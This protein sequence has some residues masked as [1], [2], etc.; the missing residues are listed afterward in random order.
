MPFR[1]GTLALVFGKPVQPVTATVSEALEPSGALP[2]STKVA[3][4]HP[5]GRVT[6]VLALPVASA[7]VEVG[8]KV[9]V[10]LEEANRVIVLS[11]A[12]RLAGRLAGPEDINVM[13]VL[14]T[15]PLAENVIGV[16]GA[17]PWTVKTNG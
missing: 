10:Q 15:G 3:G 4:Q 12:G 13:L 11:P 17:K 8:L 14:A 2:V 7:I 9:T 16:P 5:V 6:S 1:G